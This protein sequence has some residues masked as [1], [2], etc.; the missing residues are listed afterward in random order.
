MTSDLISTLAID[1]TVELTNRCRARFGGA[2]AGV[3]GPAGRLKTG[4]PVGLRPPVDRCPVLPGR[5]G[6][7]PGAR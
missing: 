1:W 2:P 7:V 4:C 6:P 3:P 5:A